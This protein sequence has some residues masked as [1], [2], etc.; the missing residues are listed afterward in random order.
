MSSA[1]EKISSEYESGKSDLSRYGKVVAESVIKALNDFCAQ[2]SE[3][4]QAVM[5]SDKSVIDCIGFTVKGCKN[6]ISDLD[7]YRRAVQFYFSGADVHMTLTVDL[8]DGGFSNNTPITVSK[9][10]PVELSLDSL[11]DF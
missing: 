6:A 7:V 10:K 2:N 1:N 9:S 11:L 5:Q 3:F 4:A 8:G